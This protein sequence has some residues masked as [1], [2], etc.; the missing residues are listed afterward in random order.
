[1]WVK[2]VNDFYLFWEETL[3]R[4]RD[5]FEKEVFSIYFQLYHYRYSYLLEEKVDRKKCEI[6]GGGEKV[7]INDLDFNILTLATGQGLII[8]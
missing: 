3:K 4:Y 6:T 1:M 7:K 2:D 8:K 5:Y